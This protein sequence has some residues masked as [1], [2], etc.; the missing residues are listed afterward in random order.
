MSKSVGNVIDPF[1]LADALRR[2]PAAL[3][4][5]ARGAV[6]T[7]RQLLARGDRQP[8]QCRSRQRSRQSRAALAVD[9]RQEL[10]RRGAG[11]PASFAEADQAIL[12]P[13]DALLGEGARGDAGLRSCTPLLADDLGGRGGR[14]PLLRRAGALGEAQDRSGADG[15]G[16][17]RDGG[18]AARASPSWRSPYA[19]CR[20]Q[21]CS[22]CSPSPADA[23]ELRGCSAA[24]HCAGGRNASLPAP[25][26]VFPRYVEPAETRSRSD[27]KATEPDARRQPLPSRFP[28]FRR[29]AST[30]RRARAARPASGAW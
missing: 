25:A 21:S 3:F 28:G 14:Q 10:R 16:A 4:L 17:L 8:H 11:S 12:W 20:R 22:T 6:R 9:D 7:G 1:T 15:D 18:S 27:R 26:P 13:R 24:G 5:P 29:R 19:D 2:R 23:A 30:R